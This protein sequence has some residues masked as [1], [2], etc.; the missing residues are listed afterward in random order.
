MQDISQ[1]DEI[2]NQ[3]RKIVEEAQAAAAQIA[4]SVE[5]AKQAAEVLI[6]IK[7]TQLE[8]TSTATQILAVKTKVE[9]LQA[10]V[11]SKS[12]HI[13]PRHRKRMPCQPLRRQLSFLPLFAQ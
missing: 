13:P 7:A 6:S 10:V 4:I 1:A 9:D 11:A 5:S 3:L 2:L 8:L 12:T